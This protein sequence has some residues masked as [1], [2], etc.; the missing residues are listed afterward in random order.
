MIIPLVEG[1]PVIEDLESQE[2]MTLRESKNFIFKVYICLLFQLICFFISVIISYIYNPRIF[3]L[4]DIGVSLATLSL[5]LVLLP[6]PFSCCCEKYFAIFPFNVFILILFTLGVSYSV[7][8]ISCFTDNETVLLALGTTILDTLAMTI[9]G[10]FSFWEIYVSYFNQLICVIF[11]TIVGLCIINL[12][13]V[14]PYLDYIISATFSV[15]FSSFII[16]DTK[17]IIDRTYKVYKKEDFIIAS[18]N[19][20]LDIINLF[21]CMIQCLS[22]QSEIN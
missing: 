5:F 1:T 14:Q 21:M 4:S 19:L 3:Y 7:G 10:M 18:I 22:F 17:L 11:V 6:I 20:Y 8:I 13:I 15:L 2:G 12:F 9:I 16:F